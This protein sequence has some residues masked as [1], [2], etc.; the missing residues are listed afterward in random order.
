[1]SSKHFIQP[2]P[3]TTASFTPHARPR[4]CVVLKH[5]VLPSLALPHM[6]ISSLRRGRL[7]CCRVTACVGGLAQGHGGRMG[8]PV[9]GGIPCGT[10]C[11]VPVACTLFITGHMAEHNWE[12]VCNGCKKMICAIRWFNTVLMNTVVC[13]SCFSLGF[14]RNKPVSHYTFS[15]FQA[16]IWRCYAK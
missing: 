11:H 9:L 12:E 14:E 3:Y 10:R 6:G 4:P 2:T 1:M 16:L 7:W 8:L 5:W 13:L 15:S